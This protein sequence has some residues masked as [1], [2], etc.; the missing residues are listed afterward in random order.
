M[1]EAIG[2][3]KIG[4]QI[5]LYVVEGTEGGTSS[6]E[7][8]SLQPE[9]PGDALFLKPI[10]FYGQDQEEDPDSME[11]DDSASAAE[12]NVDLSDMPDLVEST[13]GATEPTVDTKQ[14]E[15]ERPH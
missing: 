12:D 11:T 14:G 13:T 9:L 7:T 8:Q 5:L 3:A 4:T 1:E 15:R 10:S 6:A 2:V